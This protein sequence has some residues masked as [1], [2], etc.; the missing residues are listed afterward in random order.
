M[1]YIIFKFEK[2]IEALL[3][4]MH[5]LKRGI[6]SLGTT[7]THARYFMSLMI[8][9][10]HQNYPQIKIQLNEGSSLDMIHRLLDVKLK[11]ESA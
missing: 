7:K 8:T 11:W 6:L 9:I 4:D 10:F 3:D 5:E 1:R 2:E